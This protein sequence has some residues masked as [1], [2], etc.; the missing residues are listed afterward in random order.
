MT[1]PTKVIVAVLFAAFLCGQVR[2]DYID[3]RGSEVLNQGQCKHTDGRVYLCV[4]VS[5]GGKF[6]NVLLDEKGEV[7]IYIINERKAL[8]LWARSSV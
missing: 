1:N 6:Y 7:A 2:A 5:N 8:L 4:A 3:L